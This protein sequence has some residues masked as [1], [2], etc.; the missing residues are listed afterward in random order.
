MVVER[1]WGLGEGTYVGLPF[2]SEIS[3]H[4]KRTSH[5]NAAMQLIILIKT[6]GLGM[7]SPHLKANIQ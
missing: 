3:S 2:H 1:W 5:A 4:I 6:T 7:C